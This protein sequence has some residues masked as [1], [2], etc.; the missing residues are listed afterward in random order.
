MM[1]SA[2]VYSVGDLLIHAELPTCFMKAT[3]SGAHSCR[4][5]LG[6]EPT[7][8]LQAHGLSVFRTQAVKAAQHWKS[9]LLRVIPWLQ[10]SAA[11][12]GGS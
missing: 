12:M 5:R 1:R 8:A 10:Q 4:T 7:P 11:Y 6:D 9:W 3:S 2:S